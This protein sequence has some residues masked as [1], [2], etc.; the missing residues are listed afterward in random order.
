ML[1]PDYSKY[2]LSR[3]NVS[4]ILRMRFLP[5]AVALALYGSGL[6]LQKAAD[7]RFERKGDTA[8]LAGRIAMVA[9]FLCLLFGLVVLWADDFHLFR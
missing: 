3:Q 2:S 1:W 8:S 9:G 6:L 4:I 5:I 7:H